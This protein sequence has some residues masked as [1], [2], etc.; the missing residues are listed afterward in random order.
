MWKSLSRRDLLAAGSGAAALTLPG[1][2]LADTPTTILNASY[3]PTRELYKDYDALFAAEWLKQSGQM[4]RINQS[5]DGSGK[6]A[7]AVIDGLEADV[8][9]LGLAYDIDSIAAR[10][11]IA[12]NWETRLPFNST[13]YTSTIAFVVRQGN[14][15][16]IHDWIDLVKPGVKVITSNPK[17]SGGARWTYLAALAYATRHNGGNETRALG[18]VRGIYKNVPV[19]DTGARGATNSFVQRGIGDVLLS[20]ENEAMLSIDEVG[21]GKLQII[22]PSMSVLAEPPVAVVDKIVDKRGTRKV[23][24]AYLRYLYSEPAQ[25]LVARRHFRP[26]SQAVAARYAAKFPKMDLVSIA[27]FGGWARAQAKNFAD[28]G[29][30]DKIYQP[31]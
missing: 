21:P 27:S 14:P 2:S 10:G 24:E 12:P 20:W 15:K 16:G 3:D 11:L 29:T 23:A 13:P 19:L 28:G 26:R 1:L 5:H 4:I 18:F 9:T 22:R 7:R 25:D 8:V 17:T 6:Q 31:G 30:F